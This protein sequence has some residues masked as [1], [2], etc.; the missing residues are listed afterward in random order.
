MHSDFAPAILNLTVTNVSNTS[1]SLSWD[2]P[3]PAAT[4][5]NYR[6]FYNFT[7][8]EGTD[9]RTGE[10]SFNISLNDAT[11]TTVTGLLPFTEYQISVATN[12]GEVLSSNV[13]T[14]N[15]T[16]EGGQ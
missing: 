11:D 16:E 3:F 2:L 1:I 7:E 5:D 13:T 10:N 12:Y 6:I 14:I 9:R 4:P 8:L 15:Q